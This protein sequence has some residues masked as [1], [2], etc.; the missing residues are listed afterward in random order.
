MTGCIETDWPRQRH[1]YG[2]KHHAGANRLAHRWAWEQANGPIP[3][4]M[5]VCHRCDNPPCVNPDHLFLGTHAD[6]IHDRDAKGRTATGDRNGMRR[7]PERHSRGE[8]H[9]NAK[10]NAEIV[11]TMRRRHAAGETAEAL[12]REIGISGSHARQIV[13][14]LWWAHVTDEAIR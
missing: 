13:R 5:L 2:L 9:S 3:P 14:G 6:N 1:G 12:A 7:H 4:G 11:R 10:L 8:A